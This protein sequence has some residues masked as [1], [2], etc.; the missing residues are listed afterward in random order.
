MRFVSLRP[1]E[2]VVSPDLVRSSRS[3]QFEERLE[4][5]I[6]EIGLVEPLKVAPLPEGQFLIVD[7][8]MRWRAISA[9]RQRDPAAFGLVPAY[10][11]DYRRRYEIRFQTDIYQDLLPSQLAVLVEHL[12][13]TEQIRKGEIAKY[14]G[15]SPATLRNYTGLWRLLE[16]GGL[17]AQL[18]KLMDA[19][20]IPASNPYAWLRLTAAGIRYAL[21]T[22]FGDGRR[23][24]V[25]VDD[26][27]RAARQGDV[28]PFPIKFIEAVT[29]TLSPQYYLAGQDVRAFKRDLGLRRAVQRQLP[30]DIH[31]A[32]DN[33]DRVASRSPEKVLR[34]AARSL[35]QFIQ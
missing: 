23:A 6:Q 13:K 5:S 31:D 11:V 9:I 33:L 2:I 27:L 12:H 30:L 35:R 8:I 15:V 18:V 22:H 17:F 32:M 26:C 24:E 34:T 21:E 3:K 25:W 10:I 29:S 1:E 7:G 20:I 19:G 28:S 4:A 14:I 16:R